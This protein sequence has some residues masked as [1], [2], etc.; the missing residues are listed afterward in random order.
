MKPQRRLK[1][2]DKIPEFWARDIS[3]KDV[4]SKKFGEYTLLAFLRYAGCPFCNMAIVRLAHEHKLLKKEK[5]QVIA[6]IQST[7][8]NIEKNVI[9]RHTPVPPFP[10]VADQEQDIY[11][12]FGVRPSVSKMTA[13]TVRHMSHWI[14]AVFEKG[15]KQSNIDGEAFMVPAYFLVDKHGIIRM[16][17]YDA[18][19]YEDATFTP[20][21]EFLNF[22]SVASG[23]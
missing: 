21:Y 20:I 11:K 13:H 18:S 16:L 6:F 19:L 3:G 8:E 23:R 5:C 10:I 2:G 22:G 15:F 9:A 14:D 4:D 1:V 12:M 7:T 17:D